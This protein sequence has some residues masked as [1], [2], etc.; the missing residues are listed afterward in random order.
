MNKLKSKNDF[1][2]QKLLLTAQ[3][4][5]LNDQSLFHKAVIL[6]IAFLSAFL[7]GSDLMS[8]LIRLLSAL[9]IRL[10]I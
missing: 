8:K 3:L 7:F 2:D 10:T 9:A 6:F 4:L 1:T 5:L